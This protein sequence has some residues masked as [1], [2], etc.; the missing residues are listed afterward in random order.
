VP[1]IRSL[2]REISRLRALEAVQTGN[3]EL[4]QTARVPESPS[5]PKTTRN[6]ALGGIV[7]LVLGGALA[8]LIELFD[9]KL[10]T[11]RD[12]ETALGGLPVLATIPTFKGHS[13]NGFRDLMGANHAEIEMLRAHLRY[14]NID[15]EI[16][17]ILITSAA[18]GEGKSTIAL[19]LAANGARAGMKTL[20][21]EADFHRP[22]LASVTQV[23]PSP[24]LSE[25]LSGQDSEVREVSVEGQQNGENP[26][27]VLH[28]IPAGSR[29]PN[30]AK[31]LASDQMVT[32]L[33]QWTA[34]YDL[35]VIDT[36]PITHVAD[37]IPLLNQ[38][39]GVL[40]VGQVNKTTRDAASRLSE[41][42]ESLE[43]PVLGVVLNRMPSR[44]GYYYSGD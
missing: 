1:A 40:V 34:E 32:L 27:A 11:S 26:E 41:Q 35:V 2:R 31:L 9:R 18:G 39:D 38:V 10:R 6:V 8:L 12:F 20:L 25:M 30:P 4:V 22:T 17:S 33:L 29:P 13:S 19:S 42:L 21:V 5:S 14:F 23:T 37:P 43:A 24:G 28:L 7:G 3:A 15:R 36:P 16:R 44:L